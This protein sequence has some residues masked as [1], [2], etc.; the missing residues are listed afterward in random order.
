M[1]DDMALEFQAT[2]AQLQAT[3][4]DMD[5]LIAEKGVLEAGHQDMEDKLAES[6]LAQATLEDECR[7]LRTE[8]QETNDMYRAE[9]G[10]LRTRLRSQA[11]QPRQLSLENRALVEQNRA[12]REEMARLTGKSTDRKGRS[13]AET[14]SKMKAVINNTTKS[15][16]DLGRSYRRK[17]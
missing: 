6:R 14:L 10:S 11:N 9:V 17:D 3:H 12:L 8:V 15:V 16:E 1:F 4:A 5:A 2:K 13:V 7:S